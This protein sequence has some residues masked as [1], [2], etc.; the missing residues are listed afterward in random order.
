MKQFDRDEMLLLAQV[1]KRTHRTPTAAVK[2]IIDARRSGASF[3]EL[4]TLADQKLAGDAEMLL[5]V[6]GWLNEVVRPA[7]EG[8][9]TEVG[10]APRGSPLDLGG[11]VAPVKKGR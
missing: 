4:W 5:A 11:T 1:E 9:P 8:A 3:Q 2:E 7:D 10:E 6:R